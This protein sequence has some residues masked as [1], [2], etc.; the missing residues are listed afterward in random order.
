[1]EKENIKTSAPTEIQNLNIPGFRPVESW[2][3]ARLLKLIVMHKE[4]YQKDPEK[5]KENLDKLFEA[6]DLLFLLDNN[7]FMPVG[8]SDA[9]LNETMLRPHE[10]NHEVK[11]VRKNDSECSVEIKLRP[12]RDTTDI[13]RLYER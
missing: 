11:F 10:G 3:F 7:N 8:M 1:M 4:I 6:I 5:N 9:I 12:R 13:E 2:K